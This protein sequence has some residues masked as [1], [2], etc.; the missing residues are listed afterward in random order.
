MPRHRASAKRLLAP[1][2]LPCTCCCLLQ[3]DPRLMPHRAEGP[4]QATEQGWRLL[5]YIPCAGRA[6]GSGHTFSRVS[7]LESPSA[8]LQY[9]PAHSLLPESPSQVVSSRL[10]PPVLQ[11]R[12]VAQR[13]Q[14]T[15]PKSCK[16]ADR[17]SRSHTGG[18]AT[19]WS[20]TEQALHRGDAPGS[21]P[22]TC[23]PMGGSG[24]AISQRLCRHPS[25]SRAAHGWSRPAERSWQ[26][27][28]AGLGNTKHH[29]VSWSM[30]QLLP[31]YQIN[32]SHSACGEMVR[33]GFH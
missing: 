13:D 30:K 27:G 3:H 17:R 15:C 33:C 32:R 8:Q 28:R 9:L 29:R 1:S 16:R 10:M 23:L 20:P 11:K 7:M 26:S 31:T 19:T 22:S 25:S 2:S 18:T 24:S 12:V 21:P 5:F 4:L 6:A 14:A